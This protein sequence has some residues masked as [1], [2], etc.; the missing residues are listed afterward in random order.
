MGL[1]IVIA[2]AGTPDTELSDAVSVE[3]FES[4][5]EMTTFRIRYDLA[6]Q[7]GDF[8]AL[9]DARLDP[10]S[11]VAVIAPLNDKNNYLVKGPVTAQQIHFVH[12]G[13][14]SYVEVSG[15]DTS[16]AMDRETKSTVWTDL[17]DSDAVSTIFGQ[18]GYTPDVDATQAG[19]FEA[20]H[21]LVQRES[22]LSFV[23]RLA[24]RNGFLFWITCDENGIETARFKRP[25]LEGEPAGNIDINLDSNNIA[26]LDLEWDVERPTSA[27]AAQVDLSDKS[28]IDG[29]VEQSPLTPLGAQ[30]LSAIATGTRSI[31]VLMPVDDSGDLT[32]R[33]EAALIDSGWFIRATCQTSVN[34]MSAIIRANSLVNLRGVGTRHSGKYYVKSVRHTIDPSAHNMEIELIRN[35]WG[36]P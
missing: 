30:P 28:A 19:H 21:T 13:G 26:A 20:K 23:R 36:N 11:E 16:I 1:G 18:Y 27:V 17:T 9:V 33:G 3:V 29:G 24:R 34:A 6:I 8:P 5:S 14:G 4:M 25:E 15:A 12:G 31:H 35:A 7:E 2:V 32:A 10:G 22:D